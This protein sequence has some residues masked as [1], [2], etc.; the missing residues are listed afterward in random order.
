MTRNSFQPKTD[1]WNTSPKFNS[2]PLKNDA[3]KTIR[4]PF[5]FLSPNFQ[6]LFCW[7]SGVFQHMGQILWSQIL[8]EWQTSSNGVH[9]S[10]V[11]CCLR[12]AKPP[13]LPPDH[14]VLAAI[15]GSFLS[16]RKGA[17]W[18]WWV[19]ELPHHVTSASQMETYGIYNSITPRGLFRQLQTFGHLEF[20]RT[21]CVP[22]WEVNLESTKIAQKKRFTGDIWWANIWTPRWTTSYLQNSFTA[23]KQLLY[24]HLECTS[25]YSIESTYL[26][27]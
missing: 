16:A 21:P 13:A 18:T 6:G 25:I 7:T 1:K 12:L 14:P 2:S 5:G 22:S 8:R 15:R 3:W 27:T 19:E 23:D 26:P 20:F 9:E 10:T 11:F 17:K 4:L 24:K